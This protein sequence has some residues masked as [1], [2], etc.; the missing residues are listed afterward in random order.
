MTTE[1]IVQESDL[2]PRVR[3]RLRAQVGQEQFSAWF[4][5]LQ[6]VGVFGNHLYLTVPTPFIKRW[7]QE[8]FAETVRSCCQLEDPAI[9]Y[10]RIG[11]RTVLRRIGVPELKALPAPSSGPRALPS[12][13]GSE[14]LPD[15]LAT[16][17]AAY[18]SR[19]EIAG[20]RT[21]AVKKLLAFCAP[22]KP[23]PAHGEIR[24]IQIA[25]AEHFG[26]SRIDMISS[27]R[28]WNV[29]Q[30]R[31]V[32]MYLAKELTVM[33]LPQ[34]GRQFGQR[35]HTTVLHAVRK[36]EA[37]RRSDETVSR[38]VELLLQQLKKP[39]EQEKDDEAIGTTVNH[40]HD[41]NHSH[42]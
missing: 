17:I 26:I 12:P 9:E 20:E 23:A 8:H 22:G 24:N 32:A 4:T 28:T 2:W 31:Q 38:V 29:V 25:V 34:I 41:C 21:D 7:L 6:C 5:G 16:A 39:A 1:L 15:G 36:I 10:I 14:N 30:P 40:Q 33:S 19:A 11:V 27:R 13:D 18:L 37:L 35:D 3:E 42:T